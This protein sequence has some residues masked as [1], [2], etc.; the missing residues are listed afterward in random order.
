MV[1]ISKAEVINIIYHNKNVREFIFILKKGRNYNPGSFVQLTL[2]LVTAS[3]IWPDSRTFSIASFQK[4]FIRLIIKK[5]GYYTNRIFNELREGCF[6][7]IKYPLG[8]LFDKKTL[9]EKHVF[10]AGGLGIT[11]FLSLL[12]YFKSINKLDDISMLYSVKH[13]NDLLY[14]SY[15]QEMLKD[16]LQ[17]F[18]TKEFTKKYNRRR[19]SVNDIIAI[20]NKMSNIYVCGSK[21]F[22]ANIKN[23]LIDYEY[24][25]IH[26]DEWN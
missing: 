3:D 9:G 2:D 11:P 13:E 15:I 17:I 12:E 18:I 22:N 7:T 21:S 5:Q 19:L 10:I 25:R 4:G 1:F 26:C 24:E 6:C 20:S 8:D 14:V 16:R 23:M